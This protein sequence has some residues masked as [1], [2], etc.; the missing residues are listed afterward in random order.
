MAQGWQGALREWSEGS[1]EVRTQAGQAGSERKEPPGCMSTGGSRLTEV[2]G[3]MRSDCGPSAE[4]DLK[5]EC[6]ERRTG[7]G[8]AKKKKDQ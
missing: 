5:R 4:G 6:K 1:E 3:W 7:M 2:S 8:T